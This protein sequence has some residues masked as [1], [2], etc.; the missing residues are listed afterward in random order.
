MLVA[1]NHAIRGVATFRQSVYNGQIARGT[2]CSYLLYHGFGGDLEMTVQ[3]NLNTIGGELGKEIFYRTLAASIRALLGDERDFL[4]NAANMAAVLYQ[5]LPAVN[6][7]GF[8]LFK[9]QDLVLGPFQGKPACTR[10]GPSKGVCGAAASKRES[11][12]VENVK[13]FPG[14]IACDSA[15]KS[16]I[17]IPMVRG[18]RLI[19]V[20][21]LDSPIVARFDDEDRAG[22][23]EIVRLLLETSDDE[24]WVL[25]FLTTDN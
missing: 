14:H 11:V 6:W 17:V 13:K 1:V 3:V 7:A 4:A 12:V 8:Y 2:R 9:G 18:G 24:Y 25:S 15:S 16:E 22:L 19:G 21:D 5:E 23:E 20:L 10:I